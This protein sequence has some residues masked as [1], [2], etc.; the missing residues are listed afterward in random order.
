[1]NFELHW[2]SRKYVEVSVDEVN[3]GVLNAEEARELAK[4]LISLANDLL[5][6]DED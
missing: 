2:V 3:T 5:R 1:M 4:D 6:V